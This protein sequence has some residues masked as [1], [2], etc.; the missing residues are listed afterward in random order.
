[1]STNIDF[2]FDF[3]SPF[4]YPPGNTQAVFWTDYVVRKPSPSFAVAKAL[5]RVS[6]TNGRRSFW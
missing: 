3:M 6:I 5:P 4:A 1:M 2:Y